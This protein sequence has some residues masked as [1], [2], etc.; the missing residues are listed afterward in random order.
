MTGGIRAALW[1][2]IFLLSGLLTHGVVPDDLARDTVVFI[3]KG[4]NVNLTDSSNYR[5][6]ALSSIFGKICDLVFFPVNGDRLCSSDLQFDFKA[7]HST[8]L[9]TMVLK[10]AIA[11]YVNN[12]SSVFCTLLDATK[13]FDHVDYVKMFKLSLDRKLPPVCITLLVNMYTSQVTHGIASVPITSA[14]G[15]E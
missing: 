15:T 4:K 8:N 1:R 9:C 14:F 2:D 11:Y 3:P 10:E 5:S 7:K 13:A 12:G 6:I